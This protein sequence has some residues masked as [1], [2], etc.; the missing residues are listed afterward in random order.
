MNLGATMHFDHI[1]INVED[2]KKSIE[3]YQVR[4]GAKIEYEDETW[5]ML[6]IGDIKLALTVSNQH[7]PHVAFCVKDKSEFPG[8][9]GKISAHRDG[10]VYQY[11]E[12]PSGNI[13]EYIYWPPK[14]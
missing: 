2:I 7:P 6:K 13:I 3:W 10:S 11:V 4:L 9:L 12:D 14:S 1:A 8:P 5:A